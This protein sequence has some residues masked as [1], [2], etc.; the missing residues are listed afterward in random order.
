MRQEAGSVCPRAET[1]LTKTDE[2]HVVQR[3]D[4][5]GLDRCGH[6]ADGIASWLAGAVHAGKVAEIWRLQVG[7][8]PETVSVRFGQLE[9]RIVPGT[10]RVRLG[11]LM[12]G[13]AE[14]QEG[15]LFPSL[16]KVR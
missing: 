11:R 14:R 5:L 6:S 3:H 2:G 13:A 9:G 10:S 7:S 8:F 1:D 12:G 4:S 15:F 16:A